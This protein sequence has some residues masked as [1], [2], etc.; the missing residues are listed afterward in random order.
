MRVSSWTEYSLI[1]VLHLARRRR[2]GT[3]P[4]AARQIAEIERLPAHYVEQI[5]LRLRRAG[6]VESIRGARG[7]YLLGRGADA[8]SVRD[9]MTASEHQLFD[10]N[11]D[12]HQVDADR[13]APESACSIRPVWLALQQ[14][15]DAFLADVTV[16]GLLDDESQVRELVGLNKA[17]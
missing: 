17:S 3:G 16:A 4:V 1:I 2:A 8:I 10:L 11:C 13:C 7:G 15:I 14:R 5:L 9:V 6:L 12:V